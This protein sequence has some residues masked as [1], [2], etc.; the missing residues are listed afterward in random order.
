MM[1]GYTYQQHARD[2]KAFIKKLGLKD[3]ILD[4][5]SYGVTEQL[6]FHKEDPTGFYKE[7][8]DW[9]LLL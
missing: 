9:M 7:F 3:I 2:L 4:G 1:R 8:S 6:A 5:W